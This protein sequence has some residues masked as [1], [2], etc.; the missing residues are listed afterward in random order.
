[1][2]CGIARLVGG[3]PAS[4]AAM[5]EEAYSDGSW[6]NKVKGIENPFGGGNS[7]KRIADTICDILKIPAR[8]LKVG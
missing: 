4:L 6:A 7:G 1:M 3:E 8:A 5:L 2:E